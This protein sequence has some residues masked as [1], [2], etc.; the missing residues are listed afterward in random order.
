MRTGLAVLLCAVCALGQTRQ[1]R[2]KKLIGEVLAAL[3]G[4][5]FL[6]V[7]NRVESGRAYSFY[8]E[9][10]SGLAVATIYTEYQDHPAPGE[11][12]VRERESF[13]KEERYGAILFSGGKG[14]EITFR[15]AR[16]LSE[17]RLARWKESTARNA[18][19]ILRLRF[20]E[21]GLLFEYAGTDIQ[22]NQPV[23]GVDIID[24]EN[25]TVTLWVHHLTH[26]P[27]RQ[28]YVRRD[29]KTRQRSEEVTLYSKYRDVGGG[30]QWPYDLERLRDGE[31]TFQMYAETVQINQDLKDELFTLPPKIKLLKPAK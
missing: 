14:W 29:P 17:E 1:E 13:G 12:G 24:A 20:K 9:E 30:V 5:R 6:S 7:K 10:L 28:V 16:P 23:E 18:F 31:R 3:G 19:N 25:N 11:V 8:R 4:D 15:G 22:D 2:G 27:V 21:P 26:L